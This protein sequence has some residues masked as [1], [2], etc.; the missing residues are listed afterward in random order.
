MILY[1]MILIKRESS[2]IATI[3]KTDQKGEPARSRSVFNSMQ[4]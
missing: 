4:V 1:I 2:G 3:Y